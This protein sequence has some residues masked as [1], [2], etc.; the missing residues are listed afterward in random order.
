MWFTTHVITGAV[1]SQNIPSVPAIFSVS[2]ISHIIIDILPHGDNILMGNDMEE[3]LHAKIDKK[4]EFFL[5]A[6]IDATCSLSV[7]AVLIFSKKM[8]LGLLFWGI[9]GA[10]IFDIISSINYFVR[11]K[12]LNKFE[13][14]HIWL[15][16]LL[17]RYFK[18]GDI[19]P[20]FA[21]GLQIL[22]V[23]VVLGALVY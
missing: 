7:L 13:R 11:W 21:L 8:D 19:S 16:T 14:F 17:T 18:K 2:L 9:L 12:W 20:K 4:R 22:F 10:V 15:H 1:I 23:V 6:F 3:P 5:F